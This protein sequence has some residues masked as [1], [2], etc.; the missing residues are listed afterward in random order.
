MPSALVFVLSDSR[1]PRPEEH[2]EDLADAVDGHAALVQLVEQHAFGRRH[3]VIVAVG[4]ARECARAS[5]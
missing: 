2:V 5:R 3:G 4:R 1:M